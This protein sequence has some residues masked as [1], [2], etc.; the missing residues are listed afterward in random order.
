VILVRWGSSTIATT[1]TQGNDFVF[2]TTD[3]LRRSVKQWYEDVSYG[4]LEWTGGVTSSVLTIADPG[5]CDLYQIANRADTAAT[6]AGY[7][8]SN[9]DNR[10]YDFPSGYCHSSFGEIGG[11]RSW[12]EDGLSTA[13]LA[14]GYARMAPDHELGHNLGEYHGHGLDCGANTITSSCVIG[15][16]GAMECDYGGTAPCVSEY[17]DAYDVMGNNWT[18]DSLDGVNWFGIWHEMNLG[19]VSGRTLTDI[20][21][22]GAQ[23]HPFSIGP[24]ES[25]TGDVGLKLETAAGRTYVVEYRQPLGQDAFL[26]SYP[27]ATTGV[28]ISMANPV[29][30]F[31]ADNGAVTLDTTPASDNSTLYSDFFD[32]PLAVGHSF[33]DLGGSF[34]LKLDA[35][36]PIGASVTVHWTGSGAG[37]TTP[38]DQ[39]DPAVSYNGWRG[40]ADGSASG[41][42]YRVSRTKNDVATWR[43]PATTAVSWRTRVGPD[44]GRAAVTIDGVTKATVDLYAASPAGRTVTYQGL[45][46]VAHTITVKVLGTK[47]ASSSGTSVALD[48]FVVGGTTTQESA[49]AIAYDTWTNTNSVNADGGNYRVA[50]LAGARARVTFTGTGVDWIT[51]RGKAY[52][53]ASVTIDG[54]AK[55]TVDLYAAAQT[56]RVVL[57]YA[58]LAPGSHTMVLQLLGTKRAA[59][60]GTKVV[61]DGF[62][63]HG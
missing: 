60:T 29:A 36:S 24:I 17:G 7:T 18:G 59:A 40:V 28:T 54:V 21:P 44:Q 31:G 20:Q 55:G 9:Y 45:A 43:T 5:A 63:V 34:T 1:P 25:G 47:H 46:N 10:M 37:G 53:K 39:M 35:A 23:D 42:A 12:I 58:G 16:S 4:Q 15:A 3:P 6:N 51:A 61:L 56:W 41:G 26:A 19:W 33:S 50:S 13:D 14:D 49:P 48:A 57:G 30:G 2:G 8:L 62:T 22:S 38:M 52:G 27:E 11:P 32:A